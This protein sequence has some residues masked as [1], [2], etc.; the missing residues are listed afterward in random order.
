MVIQACNE[1]LDRNMLQGHERFYLFV[2][3]AM[4][5]V[6]QGDKPHALE[7]TIPRSNC[8]QNRA[9]LLLPRGLLYSTK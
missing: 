5:Y 9:A 3:R 8:S 6:A 4:A 1:L 2:D 7:I